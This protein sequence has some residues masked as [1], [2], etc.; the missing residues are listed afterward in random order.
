MEQTLRDRVELVLDEHVRPS[1]RTHL[2]DVTVTKIEAG[3]LHVEVVGKCVGCPS[4]E[5]S[6]TSFVAD[7]VTARIP[8]IT[9]VVLVSGVSDALI[10]EAKRLLTLRVRSAA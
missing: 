4:A 8:E 5:L 3:N 9:N 1:L 10:G 7:E 2:G 6:M